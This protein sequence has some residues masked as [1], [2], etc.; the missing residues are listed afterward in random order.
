MERKS[1]DIAFGVTKKECHGFSLMVSPELAKQVA[2]EFQDSAEK[3]LFRV[4]SQ[5]D[6]QKG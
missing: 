3:E 6:R 1:Y 2:N 5:F 4:N